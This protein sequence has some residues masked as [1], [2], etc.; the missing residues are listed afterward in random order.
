MNR[1]SSPRPLV[2]VTCALAAGILLDRILAVPIGYA[3]AGAA[4]AA[5]TF[6]AGTMRQ[7]ASVS[8]VAVYMLIAAGGALS[9]H[10]Q[11][12]Q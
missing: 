11:Y 8:A 3:L 10:I 7:M 12:Y 1:P 5:V 6:A 9:H 2:P 4:V